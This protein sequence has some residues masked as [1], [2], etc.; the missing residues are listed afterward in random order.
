MTIEE[1][2]AAKT[3]QFLLQQL[4]LF[5]I[6]NPNMK[7]SDIN[8]LDWG[9]GRGISVFKLR[10]QGFNALGLEIDETTL[11]N[12]FEVFK[13]NGINPSSI[14]FHGDHIDEIHDNYFHI[15]FSEQVIEHVSD[16]SMFVREQSR[17]TLKGGI[18][19]HKF[20]GGKCITEPHLK[21]P[22][23]HWLPKN[24]M[25]KIFIAIMLK[26]GRGPDINKWPHAQEK[27]FGEICDI[28]YQYLNEKTHYRDIHDIMSEYKRN[29]FD[30]EYSILNP[31]NSI[32]ISE[33][34]K[35]NGFPRGQ[36]RIVTKKII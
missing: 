8:I 21:I 16:L 19:I 17:L 31:S 3:D 5:R 33:K 25:R 30:V 10:E 1:I 34:L 15:I 27:S 2:N 20:P 26:S 35:R 14:L 12:G 29:G 18:G 4:E 9:C 23:V 28:Y 11:H 6:N 13:A 32:L 24:R 36:I 22:L 7:P